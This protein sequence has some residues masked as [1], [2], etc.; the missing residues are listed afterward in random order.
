M[1]NRP[2]VPILV[3]GGGF[4]P[5]G[6]RM[7]ILQRGCRPARPVA[8]APPL[9]GPASLPTPLT[10]D[11]PSA[12]CPLAYAII[13]HVVCR[14]RWPIEVEA[15]QCKRHQLVRVVEKPARCRHVRLRVVDESAFLHRGAI[16]AI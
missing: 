10:T 6:D 4:V 2:W 12:L 16:L 9:C 13:A 14:V 11:S 7:P 1:P 3:Q 15:W 5:E 8:P